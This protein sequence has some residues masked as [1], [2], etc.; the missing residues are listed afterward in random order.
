V[1]QILSTLSNNLILYEPSQKNIFS[2]QFLVTVVIPTYNRYSFI[3]EAIESVI[4]Q[5][6]SNWELIIVDDG[7]T[8]D[9]ATY[10]KSIPD[11][12]IHLLELQH[13]GNIAMLRNIGAKSA[14]G[15]WITF[16]DSDDMWVPE[17]LETQLRLLQ[18]EKKSWGYGGFELM[19]EAG[20]TI[21]NKHGT[22]HPFS[23]K[24]I[25]QLIT[26]EAS[27]NIGSLI[28]ERRLFN[29][30][31]GFDINKKLF[32]REDYD[33]ALRLALYT[34]VSV[35]PGL[36]VRIREH[37]SRTTIT[38]NDG[39]ERSAFVY[40]NFL[41]LC[42][43]KKLI[44]IVKQQQA[45]H[46]ADASIKNIKQKSYWRGIKQFGKAILKGAKPK[47]LLSVLRNSFIEVYRNIKKDK[48]VL[49]I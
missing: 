25:H 18:K 29:E 46:L 37:K 35:V 47:Q 15:Q 39:P 49:V 6:Y 41:S 1:H 16:L 14:S 26:C 43:D 4:A 19:N 31:G 40:E 13:C 21:A 17:K 42:Q 44:K 9:T 33:F 23:G 8:D 34:E 28:I 45:Y 5:T 48:L 20:E 2:E 36:L 3:R 22:Y 11:K 38:L 12:R 30:T 32:C 7:S 24:I 10:I 27:V